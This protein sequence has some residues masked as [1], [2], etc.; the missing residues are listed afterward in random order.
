MDEQ[1]SYVGETSSARTRRRILSILIILFWLL[2]MT[3][4]WRREANLSQRMAP[5]VLDAQTIAARWQDVSEYAL[6]ALG[7]TKVGALVT[8]TTR[9]STTPPTYIIEAAAS[10]QLTP[11]PIFAFSVDLAA[12]LDEL[13]ALEA[14]WVAG[15]LPTGR[16]SL[17]GKVEF[18]D[19]FMEYVNG[20]N[21]HRARFC[22][23]KPIVLADSFRSILLRSSEVRPGKRFAFL[24]MDPFW[25]LRLGRVDMEIGE[26]E[27]I[28]L[29]GQKQRAYRVTTRWGDMTTE[30]WIDAAG[31]VLRQQIVGNLYLERC[32]AREVAPFFA[33]RPMAPP[34]R[35]LNTEQFRNLPSQPFTQQTLLGLSV[36]PPPVSATLPEKQN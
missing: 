16:F 12:R 15:T 23:E 27:E 34:R 35:D 22:L 25:N 21:V 6:L 11:G 9:Q 36:S 28:L 26:E 1:I 18:P 29:L 2:M 4:L 5:A 30:G 32:L 19:L 14:F 13:F 33:G 31:R 3:L 10:A 7:S 20:D 24:A 17:T 8:T